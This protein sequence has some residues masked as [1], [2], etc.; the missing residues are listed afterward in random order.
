MIWPIKNESLVIV[1]IEV[2]LE[3]EVL[4]GLKFTTGSS[5]EKKIE[6]KLEF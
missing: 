1:G 6:K 3:L 2:L 4:Q 5:I